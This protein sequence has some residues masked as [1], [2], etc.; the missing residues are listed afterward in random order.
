MQQITIN[1]TPIEPPGDNRSPKTSNGM[2][3]DTLHYEDESLKSV[4]EIEV[5]TTLARKTRRTTL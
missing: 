4:K 1:Q 5:E 3:I 2:L